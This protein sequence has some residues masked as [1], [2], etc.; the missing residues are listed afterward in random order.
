M[1][2]HFAG[3]CV[4]RFQPNPSLEFVAA[5]AALRKLGELA[6]DAFAEATFELAEAGFVGRYSLSPSDAHPCVQLL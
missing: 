4:L 3:D 2:G 1:R 6:V 5:V